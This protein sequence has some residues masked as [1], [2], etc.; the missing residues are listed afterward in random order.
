MPADLRRTKR[1]RDAPAQR[2]VVGLQPVR[3][4]LAA[5]AAEVDGLWL[6]ARDNSRLAAL[7][8]FA[9]D[10]GVGNVVRVA[11]PELDRMSGGVQ[12]Q[13]AV[14]FAPPLKVRDLD[15]ALAHPGPVLCLDGVEDPQN[16]GAT[17]RSA[18][19]LG[20]AAVVWGE[21]GSAPL[22][23][24]TFRASAGAI[25]HAL[26]VRVP[27]L[28]GAVHR[29]RESRPVFGLDAAG[30]RSLRTVAAPPNAALV[31]GAEGFGLSRPVRNA[32]TE[33]V[34]LVRPSG[35]AALNAS[36]AAALALYE[37]ARESID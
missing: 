7:E 28:A 17:V 3:E 9:R 35:V 24:A 27:S 25:E 1:P 32:C 5:R 37:L 12:H 33:T 21:H 11:R 22:T 20:G 10:R 30:A 18:V 13:G 14:A 23:P 15:A 29:L 6:E 4:L 26:L 19:A 2:L 34:R 31:V 36:V 16:F 8:R